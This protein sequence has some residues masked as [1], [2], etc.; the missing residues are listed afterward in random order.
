MKKLW[1]GLIWTMLVIWW[2]AFATNTTKPTT[3][4]INSL[5]SKLESNKTK[6]LNSLENS[7][8]KL[9]SIADEA[10]KFADT[11]LFDAASC[12]G[13]IP[14]ED[15]NLDY[16]KLT[17]N[18]KT[19]ILN[20]YIGLDGD[21]KR[22][23][24]QLKDTDPILLGNTLDNFYNQN[25]IK[26]TNLEN[27]YYLKSG[28]T[29]ATFLEYVKNNQDLLNGLAQKLDIIKNVNKYADAVSG[30][31]SG[32]NNAINNHSS[33]WTNMN[34]I[35]DQ[36][37]SNISMDFDTTIGEMISTRN[38]SPDIQAK[39]QIHKDN[40][41]RKMTSEANKSVYYIFSAFFD[42]DKYAELMGK[43][44]D[45]RKKFYTTSGEV[46]CSLLL[47]TSVNFASYTQDLE[48]TAD[49]LKE[50]LEEITAG[51]K[52]WKVKL[53]D[54][55]A[56][57]MDTF[58]KTITG[59]GEQLRRDFRLMLESDTPAQKP[60]NNTWAV[61]ETGS[62]S[63]DIP[64]QPQQPTPSEQTPAPSK[65][66]TF[67]QTFKKGQYHQQVK[68]LQTYLT[69][70]W[71]YKGA[72]NGVYDRT[73]IE[74]VYQFQLKNG[75]ITGKEKNKSGYGRFGPQTRAKINSMI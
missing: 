41:M 19:S 44:E 46:N 42:Y 38:P 55:E 11:T 48:S 73:T 43:Q 62:Q 74:A 7:K 37:L 2:S 10:K 25:A 18:L 33:L 8:T 1:I 69:N 22:Y 32:L 68:A 50:G 12:L 24:L 72:I 52:N 56:I 51:I 21:I 9:K 16:N 31:F 75:V 14:K 36:T 29:K 20:E 64:A 45:I 13:A 59:L 34:K 53:K 54:L 58:N 60:E 70:W 49:T 23:G 65:A 3:A 67:T 63:T 15:Q 30:A 26:I 6:L 27:D 66:A 71:F 4:Q 17:D 57:A 35:K 5:S 39:Y 47:T 28:K 40:F 61:T